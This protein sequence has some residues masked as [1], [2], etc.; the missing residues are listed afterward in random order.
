MGVLV[1][2]CLAVDKS[3]SKKNIPIMYW[4]LFLLEHDV[5]LSS[6]LV[7][8]YSTVASDCLYN[9]WPDYIIWCRELK[10]HVHYD[11]KCCGLVSCI[12]LG[13]CLEVDMMLVKRWFLVP[14]GRDFIDLISPHQTERWLHDSYRNTNGDFNK[15]YDH[16]VVFYLSDVS[17]TKN[18]WP[19]K[20]Y[21]SHYSLVS[22]AQF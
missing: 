7:A 5:A 14:M 17:A 22:H 18:H 10:A 2:C 9:A 11:T 8:M 13:Q 4:E 19:S 12:S 21:Y 1:A 16:W 3:F 15:G 20:L 6:V